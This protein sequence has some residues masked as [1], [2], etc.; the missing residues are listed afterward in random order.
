MQK[1]P[2]L[3]APSARSPDS[4]A[5]GDRASRALNCSAGETIYRT[6]STGIAWRVISGSVR[7]DRQTPE[8]EDS[9]ASL[10]IKGDIIG[11]ETMLFESYSFTATA[12]SDCALIRW[13]EGE[14]A[15]ASDL[16]K[17]LTQAERRASEVIALR[18]GQAAER[19]RRLVMLLAAPGG[20]NA[21]Q[22]HVTL[23]PRQDMAD[24]TAL[25]L[26]TV[27]RM[28]S[29]LRRAGVLNPLS[30]N[31]CASTS[32]FSLTVPPLD[33]SATQTSLG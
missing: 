30:A 1:A 11:A 22:I 17:T 15:P 10:A 6:G 19:V 13:P 8:G 7:L 3:P 16:L 4:A 23:P 26:E 31:G 12:L 24:I 33:T 18:C 27:S 20:D 14:G 32:R 2:R 5:H 9:F 21:A 28:V 29:G 25:T